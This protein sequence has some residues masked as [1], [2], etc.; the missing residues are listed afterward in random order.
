M[1]I[2]KKMWLW[3]KKKKQSMYFGHKITQMLELV[4]KGYKAATNH[5]LKNLRIIKE[6]K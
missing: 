4:D 3:L 5:V 2:N 1:K 6:E